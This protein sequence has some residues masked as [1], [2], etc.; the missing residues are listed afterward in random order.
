M[1]RALVAVLVLSALT[2]PT[3]TAPTFGALDFPGGNWGGYVSVGSFTS[4]TATWVEPSVTCTSTKDLFAP[5]VGIDGDGSPTVEQTGVSTDCS[6]GRP[7][8]RA[9]YEMYP[10]PPVYF[11]NAVSAGDHITAT[12]TRTGPNTYRLD[13]SDTTRGWTQTA[14]RTLSSQH[15]SAEA[16]IESPTDSY[17]TIPGGVQFT[18]VRFNGTDLADT[19]PTRLDADDRGTY[20]WSPSAI[21]ADGT[22][23]TVT[24]H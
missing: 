24:R 23:F 19:G 2:A 22:A 4:A 18:G 10:S 21:S 20:T 6:S 7:V 1:K 13:L 3:A 11:A 15:S 17:P 14:T 5:W 12:V 16:V 9:W 8:Y